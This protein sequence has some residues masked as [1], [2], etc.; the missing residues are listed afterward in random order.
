MFI[1][2]YLHIYT[3]YIGL[4]LIQIIKGEP[5]RP[6]YYFNHGLRVELQLSRLIT[7]LNH[8]LKCHMILWY[9]DRDIKVPRNNHY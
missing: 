4:L 8:N 1:L 2:G 3:T 9:L 7:L 5:N 6:K